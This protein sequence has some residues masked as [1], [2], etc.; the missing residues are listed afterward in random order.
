LRERKGRAISSDRLPSPTELRSLS[1]AAL[2]QLQQMPSSPDQGVD[3]KQAAQQIKAALL[4]SEHATAYTWLREHLPK[5]EW[6]P[7]PIWAEI[8]AVRAAADA[9]ADFRQLTATT[10][11]AHVA[12]LRKTR[13]AIKRVLAEVRLSNSAR[14][15]LSLWLARLRWLDAIGTT[16]RLREQ[17]FLY[18]LFER[19]QFGLTTGD[20]AAAMFT[21]LF[22]A[23]TTT[24]ETAARDVTPDETAA[25]EIRRW[26]GAFRR[27][28]AAL[29]KEV[30][31]ER[32]QAAS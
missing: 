18:H 6:K 23:L 19:F 17:V 9:T 28:F 5:I 29:R 13:A 32:R 11:K 16:G 26:F 20:P 22:L 4:A 30:E 3:P 14:E 31:S 10:A 1:N 15:E 24:E 8:Q 12:R 7:N 21:P 25:R 2:H 27:Y